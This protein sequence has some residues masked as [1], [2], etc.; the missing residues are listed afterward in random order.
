MKIDFDFHSFLTYLQ[1]FNTFTTVFLN[2]TPIF[3]IIP[4]IKGKVTYKN[5]PFLM[6][7]LNLL[8]ATCWGCY[9][10]RKSF[11]IPT[12]SNTICFIAS[13]I[14]CLIYFYYFSSKN[15]KKFCVCLPILC[16]SENAI[17]FSSIYLI[18][19]KP[20]GIVLIVL[21]ILLFI[22]PGQYIVRVIKEKDHKLIPI[23][24]TIV[25]IICSGGWLAFGILV[26]DLICIIP[27]AVG[28][29]PSILNT[30][31]WI[32]YYIRKIRIGFR[33]RLNEESVIKNNQVEIK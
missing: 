20:F 18:G 1:L 25:A 7:F 14:F 16:L 19:L 3:V 6:L 23:V 2:I 29:I 8:N 31:L 10:F 30:A 11:L 32:Y 13:L 12:I 24:T 26:K 33:H 28:L 22:A 9:W 4:L 5:I 27:N 15:I 21:N 17:I